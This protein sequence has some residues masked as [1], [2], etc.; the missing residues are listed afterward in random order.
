MRWAAIVCLA[1]FGCSKP[2]L[3]LE[4]DE[5]KQSL[6]VVIDDETQPR[7]RAFAITD[8]FVFRE[9][10]DSGDLNLRALMYDR[11]LQELGLLEGDRALLPASAT[12]RGLPVPETA[13]RAEGGDWNAEDVNAAIENLA[14]A[15]TEVRTCIEQEGCLS[16]VEG[17]DELVCR[18]P[19][20]EP[21]RPVPP[22]PPAVPDFGTCPTGWVS[23]EVE[24]NTYCEPWADGI[25]PTCGEFEVA[26]PGR[27]CAAV[28]PDCPADGWPTE[29]ATL[30]VDPSGNGGSGTRAD[31]FSTIEAAL[32]QAAAGDVI[33]LRRGRHGGSFELVDGVTLVGACVADVEIRPLGSRTAFTVPAGVT[34]T[35]KNV[36]FQGSGAV[37][38]VAG[39]LSVT[40]LKAD[41]GL[42]FRVT[43]SGRLDIDSVW[44]EG[45]RS[46][47]VNLRDAAWV[48]SRN[49]AA[50]DTPTAFYLDGAGVTLTAS[51]AYATGSNTPIFVNGGEANLH[52]A[53]LVDASS[54]SIFGQGD[55][56]MITAEQVVLRQSATHVG[57]GVRFSMGATANLKKLAMF[58]DGAFVAIY[59]EASDVSAED[60][61]I[62]PRR[63]PS[64]FDERHW[65][66]RQRHS[67]SDPG[68]RHAGCR[69]RRVRFWC[70]C[71]CS[72]VRYRDQGR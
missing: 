50:F 2:P 63:R 3:I 59:G 34:A 52:Q 60:V 36:N 27:G 40:A 48:E 72:F 21:T 51:V 24:G 54:N 41:G 4:L 65:C 28:G 64:K 68:V 30:F 29:A 5:G 26:W 42:G 58:N 47:A 35:V 33:A 70:R 31:P 9:S 1:M 49:F 67:S 15:R 25:Q 71:T 20:T 62:H 6:V 39:Q 19:C 43:E 17:L 16:V 14:F 10:F 44:I 61:L 38:E 8:G 37:A 69:P 56:A 22:E 11:S 55:D 66:G 53:V 23:T 7:L 13:Y 18:T 57:G 45:G 12:T 46:I 32:T